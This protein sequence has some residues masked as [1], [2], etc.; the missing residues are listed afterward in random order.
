MAEEGAT[1]LTSEAALVCIRASVKAS[2]GFSCLTS[3]SPYEY[4]VPTPV[5]GNWPR[6][7]V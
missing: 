7:S 3:Q 1:I 6:L 5:V 4:R 2:A